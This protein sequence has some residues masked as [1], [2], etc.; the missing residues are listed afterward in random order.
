MISQAREVHSAV[1]ASSAGGKLAAQPRRNLRRGVGERLSSL[2]EHMLAQDRKLD[3][4][5]QVLE[6]GLLS[7]RKATKG[8]KARR[9]RKASR[10][11]AAAALGGRLSVGS[12]VGA[13]QRKKR[14]EERRKKRRERKSRGRGGVE[15]QEK[16]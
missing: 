15:A 7:G 3:R 9:L 8:S 13:E 4:I 11:A 1:G 6:G 12:G 2:E 14:K 5:M 16:E 10:R